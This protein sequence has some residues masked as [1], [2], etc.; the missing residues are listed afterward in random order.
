VIQKL[1][2]TPAQCRAARAL[3]PWSQDQLAVASRVGKA[4]IANFETGKRSPIANNLS[5][6]RAALE[7]A[8]VAFLDDGATVDGGPGVRL[9]RPLAGQ[10]EAENLNAAND[11]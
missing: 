1:S 2:L 3:I 11:E 8:G 10:P 6:I 5:A 4:T 7:A 9:A